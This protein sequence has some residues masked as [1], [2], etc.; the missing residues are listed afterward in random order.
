MSMR[1][2]IERRRVGRGFE[3]YDDK[4]QITGQAK[5]AYLKSLAVPPAWRDV[6]ISTAKRTNILATGVDKA[7]RLQ[8]IYSP[9]FRQHQENKKFEKILRFARALPKMRRIT[10]EHLAQGGL[11]KEK[12]LACIVRLMDEAYFRV[13]NEE[14]SK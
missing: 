3:Y 6:K 9:K 7:G 1:K 13:G 10:D 12:V 8:Y 5:L 4:G 2:Y 14:Y 11:E